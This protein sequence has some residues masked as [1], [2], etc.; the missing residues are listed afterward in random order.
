VLDA[1]HVGQPIRQP[2][3]GWI[4]FGTAP[5]RRC[6]HSMVSETRCAGPQLQGRHRRTAPPERH[7]R[8]V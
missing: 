7:P 2:S 1:G 6:C 8:W 5:Q 4:I 3:G